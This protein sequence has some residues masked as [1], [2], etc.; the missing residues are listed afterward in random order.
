MNSN[1][2]LQTAYNLIQHE[3]L[4]CVFPAVVKNTMHS[5]LMNYLWHIN[6]YLTLQGFIDAHSDISCLLRTVDICEDLKVVQ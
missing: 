2:L 4:S 6:P 1:H 5:S 3:V